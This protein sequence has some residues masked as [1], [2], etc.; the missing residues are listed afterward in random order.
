MNECIAHIL[1]FLWCTSNYNF[2]TWLILFLL[3]LNRQLNISGCLWFLD[4]AF[5]ISTLFPP[6]SSPRKALTTE[7]SHDF[8]RAREGESLVQ[9]SVFCETLAVVVVGG[10]RGDV[11]QIDTN[12]LTFVSVKQTEAPVVWLILPWLGSGAGWV[13]SV[14][15]VISSSLPAPSPSGILTPS[16]R[17]W[18][19]SWV[20]P[21]AFLAF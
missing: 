11:L 3:L 13:C 6:S 20:S 9:I 19:T 5:F 2:I 18:R 7:K 16:P 21:K 10:G 8:G 15:N 12:L 1:R 14:L 17:H 4:S